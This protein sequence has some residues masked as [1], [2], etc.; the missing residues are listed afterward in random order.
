MDQFKGTN[1]PIGSFH[2]Q[3][4]HNLHLHRNLTKVIHFA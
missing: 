3:P 4:S 1:T 2:Q